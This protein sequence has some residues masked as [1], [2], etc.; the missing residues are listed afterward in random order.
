MPHRI[1]NTVLI[2]FNWKERF[3]LGHVKDGPGDCVSVGSC[4]GPL[5]LSW[6]ERRKHFPASGFTKQHL[7][8]LLVSLGP[9]SCCGNCVVVLSLN[10]ASF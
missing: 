1:L 9:R 3:W 4:S 10:F 8:I 5:G 2:C 6:M 7:H